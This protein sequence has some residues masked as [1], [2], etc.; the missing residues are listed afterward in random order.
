[1]TLED[2]AKQLFPGAINIEGLVN[3]SCRPIFPASNSAFGYAVNLF[4]FLYALNFDFASK[5]LLSK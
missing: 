1:M 2:D 4:Y 3:D 5:C